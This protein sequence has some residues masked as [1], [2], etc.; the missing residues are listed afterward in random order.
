M[1]PFARSALCACLLSASLA[2]PAAHARQCL[3]RGDDDT[4]RVIDRSG[5]MFKPFPQA[6]TSHACE[7]LRVVSGNVDVYPMDAPADRLQAS[8]VTRGPLVAAAATDEGRAG[9]GTHILAIVRTV[10]EGNE[11]MV[12]GSSRSADADYLREAMPTGRMAEPTAGLRIPLA[13]AADPNLKLVEVSSGGKVIYRQALP[14]RDVVLPAGLFTRGA[15]LQWRVLHGTETLTGEVQVVDGETLS[16]ART[17]AEQH[18]GAEPDALARTLR[19]ATLLADDGY[20]WEARK[21]TEAALGR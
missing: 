20:A 19:V 13:A 1:K 12:S 7:R 4:A 2:A 17:A 3:Y 21:I 9:S 5:L 11:R 10:L 8:R 16:A 6:L 14:A 15:R 18:V